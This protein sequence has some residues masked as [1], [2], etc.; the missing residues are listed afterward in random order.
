MKTFDQWAE[1]DARNLFFSLTPREKI[2]A[3][4]AWEACRDET[5][6]IL[7][8]P[9]NNLDLSWDECDDRYIESVR[10]L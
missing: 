10:K 7:Q 6:E 5:L 9:Q 8:K 2:I 4:A 1:N 3:Q